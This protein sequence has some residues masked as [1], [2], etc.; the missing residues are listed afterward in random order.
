[1]TIGK[2]ILERLTLNTENNSTYKNYFIIILILIN[3]GSRIALRAYG[4]TKV[5]AN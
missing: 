1:M 5:S 3:P 2:I 4:M